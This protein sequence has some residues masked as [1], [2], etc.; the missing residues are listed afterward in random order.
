MIKKMFVVI[1]MLGISYGLIVV[2]NEASAANSQQSMTIKKGA[3]NESGAQF[4]NDFRNVKKKVKKY[5]Q[6]SSFKRVSDN[7][8]TGK[9]GGSI[10][11]TKSVTFT[12]SVTGSIKGLGI[13]TSASKTS[14]VGYTLNADP[15]SVMYMGYRVRYSVEEG[16]NH[17][18]DIV[19]G[20][21]VSKNTY[22]VKKPMYGDYKLL[23]Y[24]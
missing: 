9:K 22:K 14:T 2:P 16:E 17:K 5:E 21:T 4:V 20:K 13:S 10:S 7:L 19:T 12:T 3:S 18:V 11:S 15:N 24:K 1:L 23:D 6:W 8:T